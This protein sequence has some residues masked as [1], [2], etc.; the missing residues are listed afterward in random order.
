MPLDAQAGE[1]EGEVNMRV[2]VTGATGFIGSAIVKELIAA[3]HRV[4]GLSRSEAG[5]KALA[6]AGAEVQ[7]GSLEDLDTLKDGAARSDGIIHTAFRHDWSNFAESCEMDKRAIEA[8]GSVLQG[9]E[10]PLI[11]TGGLAV[12]AQAPL[13]TEDD[14]PI[15]VSASYP[16]A[17]EATATAL[18]RTGINTSV[19]RLPQVHDRRKQG[20]VTHLV[21]LAREKR[22]SAYVG[23]GLHRWAAVHVRDAAHLYRLALEKGEAGARYHAVAEEGVPLRDIARVIGQALDVPVQALS[24]EEAAGHF[25][26]LARFVEW[27]L[28]GASRKT[29]ERLGWQPS[30]PG[31]I[32]DLEQL[33][34]AGEP[35]A[36]VESSAPARAVR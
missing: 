5:A 16:R 11:V 8:L 20:L 12:Q 3:G 6:S 29:R 34:P 7:L 31:L 30:G 23:E 17:S 14:P 9:S 24:H 25:G 4:L 32:A 27:D 13:A 1:P 33:P 35:E 36:G 26:F 2:F 10:R 22:V 28:C 15:P 19:I 18:W 21:A